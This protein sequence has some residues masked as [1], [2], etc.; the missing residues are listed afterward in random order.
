MCAGTEQGSGGRAGLGADGVRRAGRRVF[1]PAA[2]AALL[3]FYVFALKC[4]STLA[5]MA[6][7]TNSWR[8]PVFAFSYMLMLAYGL[9]LLAPAL[10]ARR[11]GD[12]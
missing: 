8:W 11:G 12:L 5:A 6:R 10:G 7:E 1:T 9:G 4:T 2:V 3:V